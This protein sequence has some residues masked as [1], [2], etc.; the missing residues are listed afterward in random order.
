M[1]LIMSLASTA[2]NR[3]INDLIVPETEVTDAEEALSNFVPR[4][5][6]RNAYGGNYESRLKVL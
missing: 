5:Y 1:S 3:G 2:L 4:A 6:G